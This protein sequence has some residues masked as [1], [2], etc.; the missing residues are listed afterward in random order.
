MPHERI[1]ET[2]PVTSQKELS[3]THLLHLQLGPSQE[4]GMTHWK[5]TLILITFDYLSQSHSRD[6]CNVQTTKVVLIPKITF[7]VSWFRSSLPGI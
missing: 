3:C 5:F 6:F 2:S 1:L 7:S 4:T